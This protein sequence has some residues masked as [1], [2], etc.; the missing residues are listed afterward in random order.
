MNPKNHAHPATQPPNGQAPA[1]A[2]TGHGQLHCLEHKAPS[3]RSESNPS[4]PLPFTSVS[5]PVLPLRRIP[6]WAWCV[7][8]TLT[9]GPVTVTGNNCMVQC[10]HSAPIYA[11]R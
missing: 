9:V 10:N 7:A 3:T 6:A 1:S 11:S 8:F 5:P 4:P 2:P